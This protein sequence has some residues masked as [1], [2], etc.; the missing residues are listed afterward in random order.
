[1]TLT[2]RENLTDRVEAQRR[3]NSLAT[4]FLRD[5]LDE[6]VCTVERQ[7]RGAIHFHLIVAFP[8]DVRSGFDFDA[9]RKA[10]ECRKVGDNTGKQHYERLYF[11]SANA[12]LSAWWR[13][14]REK[15]AVY[16]FGRCE[17]LPVLTS[18]AQVARYVGGYVESEW[19]NRQRRDKGMRTI[20]YSLERRAASIRWAWAAGPA[21]DW[22]RGCVVAAVIL[23]TEDFAE[24]FGERWAWRLREILPSFG[25]HLEAC[26]AWCSRFVGDTD[27][28]E[29][30]VCKLSRLSWTI[31]DEELR[32]KSVVGQSVIHNGRDFSSAAAPSRRD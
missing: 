2:F 3:F 15:A 26:L 32:G 4:N 1:M 6:W 20:R 5:E 29:E 22:R 13:L 12:K 25:R 11:A 9:A 14:L 21:K 10:A 30:A 8:Y 31:R 7:Q 19:C 17:T 27:T 24:V 18:G 28:R 16:G 23:G